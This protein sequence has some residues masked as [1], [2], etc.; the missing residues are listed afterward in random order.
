MIAHRSKARPASDPSVFPQ[1][2]SKRL[3]N[4]KSSSFAGRV[5][6][7][8]AAEPERVSF[9]DGLSQEHTYSSILPAG[10]HLTAHT[11]QPLQKKTSKIP[12]GPVMLGFFLFVVVGS[13]KPRAP[14]PARA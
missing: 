10:T 13:G 2:A 4:A 1:T 14:L 11:F 8:G 12:V 3:V 7:R 5:H 9:S 6:K